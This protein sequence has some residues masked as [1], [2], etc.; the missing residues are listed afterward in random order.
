MR[1]KPGHN[2]R[3]HTLLPPSFISM[4]DLTTEHSLLIRKLRGSMMCLAYFLC[5]PWVFAQLGTGRRPVDCCRN[6]MS[7][8]YATTLIYVARSG[9]WYRIS[10]YTLSSLLEKQLTNM[11]VDPCISTNNF[12]II[13]GLN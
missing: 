13:I 9:S 2:L 1:G 5:Y 3:P 10:S 6:L 12:V 7:V 8:L 11:Y 4:D